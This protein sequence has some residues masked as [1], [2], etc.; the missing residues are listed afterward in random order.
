M[1]KQ[2]YKAIVRAQKQQRK[3]AKKLIHLLINY[4]SHNY[5][6]YPNQFTEIAKDIKRGSKLFDCDG[7]WYFYQLEGDKWRQPDFNQRNLIKNLVRDAEF[8]LPF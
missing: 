7:L 4:R 3:P 8:D 5:A 2:Q 1:N 6:R